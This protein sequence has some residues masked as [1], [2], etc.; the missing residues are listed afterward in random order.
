M[1]FSVSPIIADVVMQDLEEEFLARYKMKIILFPLTYM[2]KSIASG[3]YINLLSAHSLQTK[4]GIINNLANKIY[5]LS[6]KKIDNKNFSL[7]KQ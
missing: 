1:G 3:R 6:D 4:I 7:I 5:S 2:K